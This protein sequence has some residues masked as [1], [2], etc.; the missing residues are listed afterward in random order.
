MDFL[1]YSVLYFLNTDYEG[2]ELVI[3][4]LIYKPKKNSSIIFPSNFMFP[5]YV[6]PITKGTRYS[7]ITC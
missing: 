1:K 2:G 5:H 4:D 3:S 6:K 7:I